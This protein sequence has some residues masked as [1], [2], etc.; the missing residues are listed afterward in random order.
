MGDFGGDS[1]TDQ[2]TG[3]VTGLE[4]ST[5]ILTGLELELYILGDMEKEESESLCEGE[6][7]AW[8]VLDKR[9]SLCRVNNWTFAS[10]CGS[11]ISNML[12]HLAYFRSVL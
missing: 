3:L 10:C 7:T 6:V 2:L 4:L 5:G 11:F 9:F 8:K 1:C 12:I